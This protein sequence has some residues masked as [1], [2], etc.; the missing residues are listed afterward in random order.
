MMIVN[1]VK[2]HVSCVMCRIN[3]SEMIKRSI[4]FISALFI[5]F[6]IAFAQDTQGWNNSKSRHF[7]VYYKNAPEDFIEQVVNKSE[8]YYL[9]ITDNMGFTR[10]DFWLWDERAKIYIYDNAKDYN[11]TTGQPNWS[12][13]A[14][15]PKEKKISTFVDS[16]GFFD[17]LL[18]HEMGHI[19]FR[20]MIGFDNY[21]APL[22]L[23]E[24][25][26]SYQE[27]LRVAAAD[28]FL[29][30]AAD[31]NELIPLDRFSQ[32]NLK[33]AANTSEIQL[34]YAQSASVIGFLINGFGSDKFVEFCQHVRDK[35]DFNEAM[36]YV[37]NFS[38]IEELELAWKEYL[39]K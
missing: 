28:M 6:N 5:S 14:A 21:A 27:N 38:N 32:V 8:D 20:E 3:F 33:G 4:I 23:E 30:E 13:G 35:K 11:L 34:F 19:I 24:G 25:V 39:R 1:S 7:I 36:R 31:N 16:R 29:R 9:M 15:V 22:W 26:A 17:S 37:Y 18:P 10:F 2:Y 12:F